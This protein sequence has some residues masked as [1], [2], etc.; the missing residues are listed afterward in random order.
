MAALNPKGAKMFLPNEIAGFINFGKNLAKI[1]P[2]V[3]PDFIKLF[4]CASLN[5]IS[6]DIL[7]S[8]F[9]LNLFICVW[10]KNNSWS[11]PAS[12]KFLLPINKVVPLLLFTASFNFLSADSIVLNLLSCIQPFYTVNQ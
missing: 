3:P 10:V 12:L 6:P 9:S 1:D 7:F 4:I 5:F 11:K 8:T 2:K